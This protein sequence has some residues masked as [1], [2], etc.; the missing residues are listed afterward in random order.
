ML[1]WSYYCCKLKLHF[2]LIKWRFFQSLWPSLHHGMKGLQDGK[3]SLDIPLSKV[4]TWRLLQPFM[5]HFMPQNSHPDQLLTYL[6]MDRNRGHVVLL[7]RL[8]SLLA[9]VL[10]HNWPLAKLCLKNIAY[11]CFSYTLVIVVIYHVIR[12]AF[13]LFYCKSHS[14]EDL[15]VWEGSGCWL[16]LALSDLRFLCQWRHL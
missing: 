14:L 16:E 13:S 4:Q 8:I 1:Q 3:H 15:W 5:P 11:Q 2:Y 6:N 7:L 12:Q 9:D 10:D